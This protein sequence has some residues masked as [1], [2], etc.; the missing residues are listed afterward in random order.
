MTIHRTREGGPP[1][2]GAEE[3]REIVRMGNIWVEYSGA[4]PT[5]AELDARLN[6]PKVEDLKLSA[7]KNAAT[8]AEV[9]DAVVALFGR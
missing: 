9:R 7:L 1:S 4:E 5:A 2:G 3:G 8:V 6:P